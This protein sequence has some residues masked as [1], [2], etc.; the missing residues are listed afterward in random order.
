[1]IGEG[2]YV[3]VLERSLYNAALDGL[4]LKGDRF[5]YGNPLASPGQY[6]R[7]A[8]FGT[9]C[10][11]ANIARLVA[12]L[13][14]Y[15]YDRS[16]HGLW[17]NLFIGSKTSLQFG[18]SIVQI[19]QMTNYPWDG[20]IEIHITPDTKTKFS[21]HLR[22]PGWAVGKAVPGNLY[23][24][25][26]GGDASFTLKVNDQTVPYQM[27]KGYAV[28]GREWKKGDRVELLLPMDIHQLES[29]AEVSANKDRAALQRGPL[30]YCVEGTDNGG[31]AWNILL[32]ENASFTTSYEKDLLDG[33][34]VLRGELPVI[35]IVADGSSV[36]TTKVQVTAIPYYSWCNR[37]VDD[38]QVW[39][40]RRIRDIK[41]NYAADIQR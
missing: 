5:F 24:F 7:S 13:G 41:I 31:S 11:P 25:V 33:V 35:K 18:K 22:I 36:A 39:L 40:P 27:E 34:V 26:N 1:L 23:H 20:K 15:I 3:D 4:S 2:K 6:E 17:V 14:N 8:W 32:P 30:I 38:M 19:E 37:S 12:S 29:S 9:A 16:D 21:L 28:I 10:C